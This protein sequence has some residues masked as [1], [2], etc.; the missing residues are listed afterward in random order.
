MAGPAAVVVAGL[1]T[2]WIAAT[3]FDGMVVDDYYKQGL[4]IN[5]VL[6]RDRAA[7]RLGLGADVALAGGGHRVRVVPAGGGLRSE[8]RLRLRLAHPAHADLDQD[9]ALERAG[10]AYEAALQP[11]RPGRWSVIL[12]DEAKSWRLMGV[13]RV[14]E[15][16]ALR[17]RA[18]AESE[19]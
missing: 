12:E 10:D 16:S 8:Q 11:L 5:K 9:I 14:P 15:D 2:Y 19:Q 18:A 3:T 4:A 13:W 7:T 6:E 1:V 17:L